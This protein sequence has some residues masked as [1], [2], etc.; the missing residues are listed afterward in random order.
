MAATEES[1]A[2][3]ALVSSDGS[4][5]PLSEDQCNDGF[6]G[7]ISPLSKDP[8]HG[9]FFG[10]ISP[11][12]EKKDSCNDG[13]SGDKEVD[14]TTQ[15]RFKL[16]S[17]ELTYFRPELL[18]VV[19]Q[20][21]TLEQSVSTRAST[22]SKCAQFFDSVQDPNGLIDSV[23]AAQCSDSNY[24]NPHVAARPVDDDFMNSSD[25]FPAS[26]AQR[27]ALIL[28]PLMTS[29]PPPPPHKAP[30]EK[31]HGCSTVAA[32][33]RRPSRQESQTAQRRPFGP[34]TDSSPQSCIVRAATLRVS[35]R[36]STSSLSLSQTHSGSLRMLRVCSTT[37]LLRAALSEL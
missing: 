7:S 27:I 26:M 19:I 16:T 35:A 30:L 2:A 37:V 6:S 36:W 28:L 5:F 20:S 29:P 4:I 34:D 3:T 15:S 23:G 33:A 10:S 25:S 31:L 11:L 22:C 32:R 12:S 8:C 13:F 1:D 14:I 24:T 21:N 17:G 18:S 9:G